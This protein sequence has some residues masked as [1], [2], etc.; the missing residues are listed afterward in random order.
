[1]AGSAYGRA[2]RYL[3]NVAKE[4]SQWDSSRTEENTGQFYGALFQ[5]RRY[6]KNGNLI[7]KKKNK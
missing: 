3:K 4:Y 7:Q 5:G 2:A 6:D 1:M